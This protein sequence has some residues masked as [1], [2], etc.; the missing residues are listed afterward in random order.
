[1]LALIK[2]SLLCL[3]LIVVP[4]VLADSE[5]ANSE[6]P[7]NENSQVSENVKRLIQIF[8]NASNSPAE[9]RARLKEGC[10]YFNTILLTTA[11]SIQLGTRVFNAGGAGLTVRIYEGTTYKILYTIKDDCKELSDELQAG[12]FIAENEKGY[13]DKAWV[14]RNVLDLIMGGPPT[15]PPG[16]A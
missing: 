7:T 6:N 4:C 8:E 9:F 11:E 1:M 16:S 3:A 10:P 14:F 15:K 12:I 13:A 2:G 5:T